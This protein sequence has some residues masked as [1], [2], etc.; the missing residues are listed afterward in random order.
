MKRGVV[1]NIRQF[2]LF[3]IKKIRNV[4]GKTSNSRSNVTITACVNAMGHWMPPMFVVKGKTS[5]S[6][7]GF[8]TEAAPVGSIWSYQ[9]NGW[10]T[11]V[12]GE[13][14]FKN[15]FLERMWTGATSAPHP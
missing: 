11:D 6:L 8:N 13:K 10:M 9:E 3:Q 5:A 2:E 15:V 1:S 7:H 12:L 14:W 4:V